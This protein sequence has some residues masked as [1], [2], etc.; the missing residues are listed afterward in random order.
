MNFKIQRKKHTPYNPVKY[1]VWWRTPLHKR[2]IYAKLIFIF[3]NKNIV[4]AIFRCRT[5]NLMF[6]GNDLS[7]NQLHLTEKK[8]PY[9]T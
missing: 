2:V 7:L 4:F 1:T 8:K 6:R 5:L 3:T 9:P